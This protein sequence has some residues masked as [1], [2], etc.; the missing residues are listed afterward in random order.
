M[1]R[2]SHTWVRENFRDAISGAQEL[3]SFVNEKI[4]K[5][6]FSSE[7]LLIRNRE[8]YENNLGPSQLKQRAR[9]HI[10]RPG[11]PMRRAAAG[12]SPGSG[13][14][15][16]LQRPECDRIGGCGSTYRIHACIKTLLYNV[17]SGIARVTSN[18]LKILTVVLK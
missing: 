2:I 6:Y 16:R 8:N 13:Q 7:Q 4:G 5:N 14:K 1:A 9:Y 17:N 15:K 10:Q 11:R 18:A 3:P 12:M